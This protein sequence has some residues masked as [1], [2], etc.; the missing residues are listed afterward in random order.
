MPPLPGDAGWLN[1]AAAAQDE[2]AAHEFHSL[3]RS[4]DETRIEFYHQGSSQN[5]L[6]V[7]LQL[8]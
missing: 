7:T 1:S 6:R 5:G 2:L 8:Q 3:L 4:I